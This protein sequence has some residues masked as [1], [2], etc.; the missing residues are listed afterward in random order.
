MQVVLFVNGQCVNVPPYADFTYS[1]TRPRTHEIVTFNASASYDPDGFIF[2]YTWDFGDGN[3]TVTFSPII[4]HYYIVS[5][6]YH[7]KLT[8]KDNLGLES[9]VAKPI[10]VLPC[11]IASFSYS[12]L[13]PI[14][15]KPV[16]F[17]A[18]ESRSE[19][20][21]IVSY[22][23]D[24]GDGNIT[25]TGEPMITHHFMVEGLYTVKL[26]VT[27]NLG[28]WDEAIQI[29]NVSKPTIMPPVASFT[30]TPP[31]PEV[32]EPILFDA[33]DSRP[34][35][36]EIVLYSWD[37]GDG[38][39][40][41]T[42]A[43][44]IIHVYNSF[45]N[46]DVTLSIIDSE[47]E[48]ASATNIVNVIERPIADFF[49]TPLQPR[50]CTKIVFNASISDPRGG[51]ILEYRWSFG[52]GSPEAFGIVVVYRFVRMGEYN[53]SLNVTDSEGKW[54]IKTL[55]L[56]VLPHIADLNEDGEV[57]IIDMSIFARAFGSYPGH[58]RWNSRVDL[59]SDEKINILDG[60]IIARSF[61]Q[62]VEFIDP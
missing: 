15:C 23:W 30:W 13:N 6:E 40:E 61:D 17:D 41:N 9:S 12:P 45:G 19:E 34:N 49:F 48:T 54:D 29:L 58:E 4:T 60:V 26:N 7:V 50:V 52:D 11:V 14:V 24:F 33:S 62:C 18:S 20:G 5:G 36:G 57:N 21:Y 59:N 39:F 28:A 8:V 3:I 43:P 56:K 1:P 38:T 16:F 31:L 46:Y 53:V 51:E 44:Q 42:S 37:F 22:L 10:S 55:T 2:S 47:G 35:G 27:D 32:N 25:V